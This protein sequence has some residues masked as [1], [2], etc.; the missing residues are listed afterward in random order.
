LQTNVLT[1]GFAPIDKPFA[2]TTSTRYN[3]A[4][5]LT[6]ERD[7]V[8]IIQLSNLVPVISEIAPR[9]SLVNGAAL[10]LK[11]K[12]EYF[13]DASK[14]HFGTQTLTTRWTSNTQLEA[15]VPANLLTQAKLVSVTVSNPGP[16]G[17]VS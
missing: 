7:E 9:D 3:Q 15:D 8:S 1:A 12:G 10:T 5:I 17:G 13:H 2:L 16:G 11:I 4:L 14:V 6:A